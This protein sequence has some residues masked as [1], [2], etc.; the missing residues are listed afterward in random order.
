MLAA[1]CRGRGGASSLLAHA[2]VIE[3]GPQD[4]R[5]LKRESCR[6]TS[7]GGAIVVHSLQHAIRLEHAQALGES[8]IMALFLSLARENR[9]QRRATLVLAGSSTSAMP[10][11]ETCCHKILRSLAIHYDRCEVRNMHATRCPTHTLSNR[12]ISRECAVITVTRWRVY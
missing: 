8:G 10:Q 1:T 5:R 6:V 3:C 4:L 7:F 2:V 9:A 12:L 11:V